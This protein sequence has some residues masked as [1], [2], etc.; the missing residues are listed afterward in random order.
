MRQDLRATICAF[1]LA[2][3]SLEY[4]LQTKVRAA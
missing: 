3:E 4:E 2:N 1:I